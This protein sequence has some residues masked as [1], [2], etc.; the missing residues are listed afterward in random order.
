[1]CWDPGGFL[2][3]ALEKPFSLRARTW[4]F[5][6]Q[7]TLPIFDAGTRKANYRVAES[8]AIPFWPSTIGP[9]KRLSAK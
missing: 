8:I 3:G 6:P 5:A 4:E 1:V 7:V 9:S 2:S